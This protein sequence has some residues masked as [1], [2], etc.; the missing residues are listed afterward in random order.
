MRIQLLFVAAIALAATDATAQ[1]STEVPCKTAVCSLKIDW[2]G[3]KTSADYPPDKRYGSGDDFEQRFSNAL[4]EKGFNFRM[5]PIDGAITLVARTTMTPRVMC[6]A[7]AG[8]NP[9]KSCT[10]MTLLAVSF[11]AP[12]GGKAPGAIRITNRCAAGD[13]FLSHREFAEYAASMIWYQLVGQAAKAE[14]PRSNC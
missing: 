6:D 12:P 11:T 13:I 14:R 1:D 8:V 9:D 10:A 2:G 5:A 7:M 3:N 4:R